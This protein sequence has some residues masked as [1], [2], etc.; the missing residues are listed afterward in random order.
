MVT[1]LSYFIHRSNT[2]ANQDHQAPKL[3]QVSSSYLEFFSLGRGWLRGMGLGGDAGTVSW[4]EV[5]PVLGSVLWLSSSKTNLLIVMRLVLGCSSEPPSPSAGAEL[6]F[7]SFLGLLVLR[8]DDGEVTRL[9]STKSFWSSFEKAASESC[10]P[11]KALK[12]AFKAV[13]PMVVGVF[14]SCLQ[15]KQTQKS[16]SPLM[17]CTG[18]SLNFFWKVNF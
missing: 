13:I 4:E 18:K 17:M 5:R 12:A 6:S 16:A 14:C 15:I 7:S 8:A 11:D 10:A 3:L 9:G 1:E 2:R